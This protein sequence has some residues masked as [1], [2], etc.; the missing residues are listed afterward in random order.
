MEDILF[1]DDLH[2]T[3]VCIRL[4]W[5]VEF[6]GHCLFEQHTGGMVCLCLDTGVLADRT[7][8]VNDMSTSSIIP[9]NDGEI[10]TEKKGICCLFYSCPFPWNS[11]SA[12]QWLSS[13]PVRSS[14][15]PVR[16]CLWPQCQFQVKFLAFGC[17][18][19]CHEGITPGSICVMHRSLLSGSRHRSDSWRQTLQRVR[20]IW[21]GRA[22]GG[23]VVPSWLLDGVQIRDRA[24]CL[25]Q[26]L[27][28][29]LLIPVK[30]KTG[31]E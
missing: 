10:H 16:P 15:I 18:C 29:E 4:E 1:D 7:S 3:P 23:P 14:M 20:W 22:E 5:Q 6:N 12:T 2:G 30:D 21:V 19:R 13:T 17:H 27:F 24:H 9:K 8:S 26:T 25:S 31:Q 28:R 11:H